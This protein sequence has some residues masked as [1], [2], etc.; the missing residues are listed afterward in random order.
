MFVQDYDSFLVFVSAW[1][2]SK[3]RAGISPIRSTAKSHSLAMAA[4]RISDDFVS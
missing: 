1:C 2:L 3:E 4:G